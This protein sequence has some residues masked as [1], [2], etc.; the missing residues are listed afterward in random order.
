MS[1]RASARLAGRRIALTRPGDA[2]SPLAV[3][4]AAAGAEPVIAPAIAI[5]PTIESSL[6]NAVRHIDRFDW[7]LFTSPR[8]VEPFVRALEASGANAARAVR[9][10]AIAGSTAAALQANG[11]RVDAVAKSPDPVALADAL[12]PLAGTRL[13]HP[14]SS[15]ATDDLWTVVTRRGARLRRVEAYRTVPA[16]GL[17]DLA[18]A[19]TTNR[20]DAAVF[21][22]GSAVRFLL[23]RA[24]RDGRPL[25]HASIATRFVSVG[26]SAAKA[27]RE[28]GIQAHALVS[29]DLV[30][31]LAS[32]LR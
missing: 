28:A 32:L 19:I 13:L 31:E 17:G 10:A 14:A 16:A 12:E 22:S 5:A 27:F 11:L 15:L 24:E 29:N 21:W 9:C 18:R 20:L 4:L 6:H 30:G 8:A 1:P 3:E 25:M 23:R 7:V 2:A 26:A